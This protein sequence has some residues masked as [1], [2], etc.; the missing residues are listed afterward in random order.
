[1]QPYLFAAKVIVNNR[2]SRVNRLMR[3]GLYQGVYDL[4]LACPVNIRLVDIKDRVVPHDWERFRF[5]VRARHHHA[6]FLAFK[7]L[8]KNNRKAFFT[9]S[10]LAAHV[11]FNLIIS[12]VDWR[13]KGR[14]RKQDSIY[15]PIFCPAYIQWHAAFPRLA[16]WDIP[17]FEGCDDLIRYNLIDS[18]F[19]H[20]IFSS[21]SP[22]DLGR[23]LCIK[24]GISPAPSALIAHNA[25]SAILSA[26]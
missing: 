18:F 3:H 23:G 21:L 7:S 22:P 9:F 24:R 4:L 15:A 16:P 13:F 25:A 19:I 8:P 12:C 20:T 14:Q 2:L 5:T 1:M 11:I 26:A 10:D 17:S 6:V